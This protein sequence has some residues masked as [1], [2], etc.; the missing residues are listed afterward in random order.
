MPPARHS[1]RT[2]QFR[3]RSGYRAE[4]GTSILGAATLYLAQAHP[5]LDFEVCTYTSDK[6]LIDP[7][8]FDCLIHVGMAP[9]SNYLCRKMG[10]VSYGIYG[11]PDL[12]RQHGVP[13][14]RADIRSMLG[15]NYSRSC[16][17]EVWLLKNNVSEQPVECETRFRVHDYWMA[18]YYAV[19][20]VALAYLPDFFVHYEVEQRSVVQVLPESRSGKMSARVIYP[21]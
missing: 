6:L 12:L 20:G 18:K 13:S 7:P 1:G 9:D 16:I 4:F 21:M 3:A 11:S 2:I 14:D 5:W 17:P 15:V 8:D 10:A 19:F